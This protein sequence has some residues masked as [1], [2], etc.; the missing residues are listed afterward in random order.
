[1]NFIILKYKLLQLIFILFTSLLLLGYNPHRDTIL[2]KEFKC[3]AEKLNNTGDSILSNEGGY[4]LQGVNV[5]SNERARSGKYSL[6]LN[7]INPYGFTITLDSVYEEYNI[8]IRIWKYGKVESGAIVSD[9]S[10]KDRY[11]KASKTVIKEEE[12]GWRLIEHDVIIPYDLPDNKLKVFFYNPDDNSI[13]VDDINVKIYNK[14]I[15]PEYKEPKLKIFVSKA[16]IEKLKDKRYEALQKGILETEDGDYV[17]A[18]IIYL[19]D[20]LKANIRLKGDW[21]DHLYG[22]KWS[23]RIKLRKNDRWEG[24]RS[25]SIQNPLTRGYLHEWIAH[26]FLDEE[27]VLTTRYGFIPVELNGKS[28][29]IYAYEEH[30]DKHLVESRN[31]REGPILKLSEDNFWIARKVYI[32][33][34]ENYNLPELKAAS[35][36]PF[37]MNRTMNSPIL[38]NDFIIA[39]NLVEKFRNG[40][41]PLY[42]IFDLEKLAKL[43]A[44]I[45]VTRAHHG[46]AWHNKRYYYNPVLCKLELILFD[47]FTEHQ[48]MSWRNEPIMGNFNIDKIDLCY[49]Y[50]MMNH[51]MMEDQDFTNLY[52]KYLAEYSNKNYL[53]RIFEKYNKELK[54]YEALIQREVPYYTYDSLF[55]FNVSEEIQN[56]LPVF[57]KRLDSHYYLKLKKKKCEKANFTKK[58]SQ[59]FPEYYV[60]AFKESD[61]SIRVFNY[62]PFEIEIK[63]NLNGSNDNIILSP[64][65]VNYLDNK[66]INTGGSVDSVQ[67]TVIPH[68]DLFKIPVYPWKSPENTSNFQSIMENFNVKN[69]SLFK[70][71]KKDIYI[72]SE[73]YVISES[74][75]IPEGYKVY[76]AAGAKIDLS[77]NSMFISYSPVYINGTVENPVIIES[78]DGTG[79]GFTIL[80]AG[81]KSIL[82]N[83]V[84][85][86]LNTVNYNNW[87]LTGAVNFYES[88][89]EMSNIKFTNNR[90]ED[91]LNIIRSEFTM[92]NCTFDNIF[93]DA[94]DSDYCTGTI[95]NSIFR[96]ISNDAT[97]FSGSTVTIDNC[98]I[99]NA[100]DKGISSG[101]KSELIV[102]NIRIN[103]TN[104]AVASKD[105]SK[106]NISNSVISNSNYGYVV[107]K[108]KPEYG[109][110]EI[111]STK[112]IL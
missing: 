20:T 29:G 85:D 70:I 21:L 41:F 93:A 62:Y 1:M 51:R 52:Y 53:E 68:K 61:S 104:I 55:L 90:C 58:Y 74:I 39:Q 78:S 56:D 26:K 100:G 42:D 47:G 96:D 105:L 73:T 33:T 24:M 15:Y 3:N 37:K 12:N 86:Q 106:V 13:Y 18:S 91:A 43:H 97:D 45:D 17:R 89:V 107:F 84:F 108:K 7:K 19:N 87:H 59:E 40:D 81:E 22:P 35:I 2:V 30:F 66:I 92:I 75:F 46:L 98:K 83:V 38:K 9:D 25:F 109:V 64:Y 8:I 60:K 111:H 72:D 102:S 57:K 69:S 6:K 63:T 5:R 44:L 94:F 34:K 99:I 110:A 77:N 31:R 50:E 82:K 49:N 71:K 54:Y 112:T 88:D 76:V 36:L 16:G 79:M 4:R 80:Q 11:F 48:V 10:Q 101:E 23:F 67:F 65:K 27:D 28:V 95:K 103:K 14:K 32:N